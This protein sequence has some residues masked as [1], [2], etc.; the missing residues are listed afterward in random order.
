MIGLTLGLKFN[1]P[2]KDW[3]TEA[4]KIKDVTEFTHLN[5]STMN[6]VFYVVIAVGAAMALLSFFGCCGAVVEN[7]CLLY[8][9]INSPSY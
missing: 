8:T 3:S 5:V 2:L 1:G 7:K 6:S 9:V 4:L